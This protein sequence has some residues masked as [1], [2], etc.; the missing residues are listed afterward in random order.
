[1][2]LIAILAGENGGDFLLLNSDEEPPKFEIPFQNATVIT[3]GFNKKSCVTASSILHE[4][5][6]S[7]QICVQRPIPTISGAI[8]CEQEFSVIVHNSEIDDYNIL[9]T[10]TAALVSDCK[11]E[12]LGAADF[13]L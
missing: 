9:A 5:S 2:S 3:Y 7:I 8:V 1:M 6:K 12:S 13:L 10:V 4:N 11:V